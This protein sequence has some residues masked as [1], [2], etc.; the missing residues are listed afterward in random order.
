MRHT[1]ARTLLFAVVCLGIVATLLG[2]YADDSRKLTKDGLLTPKTRAVVSGNNAYILGPVETIASMTSIEKIAT[3]SDGG[4]VLIA[5]YNVRPYRTIALSQTEVDNGFAQRLPELNLVYWDL[6]TRMPKTLLR[7]TVSPDSRSSIEEIQW[8]PKTRIALITIRRSEAGNL[9][10]TRIVM[11]VDTTGGTVRRVANLG[12]EGRV[13]VSWNQPIAYITT[14]AVSGTG[15]EPDTPAS[16]QVYTPQGLGRVIRLEKG[17]EALQW[18]GDG[19]SLYIPETFVRTSEGKRTRIYELTLINLQTGEV[20]HP[21]K[22]PT[23]QDNET[24]PLWWAQWSVRPVTAP[25]TVLGPT[26]QSQAATALWLQPAADA[27]N[28]LDGSMVQTPAAQNTVKNEAVPVPPMPTKWTAHTDA[29]LIATDV[30]LKGSLG[31]EDV[32]AILFTRDGT[33]CASPIFRLPRTDFEQ[34]VLAVQRQTTLMNAKQVGLGIM[35]YI[36]DYD[37]NYP[38]PSK[39]VARLIDPYV[40]DKSLFNNV[41]TG[42]PGFVY[43]HKGST[44]LTEMTSPATTQLGYITGPGGKAIIWADGHVTWQDDPPS[45]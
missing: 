19:K 32:A 23:V 13:E 2:A 34:G 11:R 6:R 10:D 15:G 17:L 4:A 38:M 43:T 22:L 24:V 26:G 28:A 39:N 3:S 16:L 45:P 41:A 25:V 44:L 27:K 12:E 20:T 1:L 8:L 35:M 30:E 9:A 21:E 31:K 42:D 14:N 5:A 29:L 40:T 33:L 7:E 36:Q 18:I 37:E